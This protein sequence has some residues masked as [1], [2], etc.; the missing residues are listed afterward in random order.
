VKKWEQ[1]GGPQGLPTSG[2]G[3]LVELQNEIGP[4]P[5]VRFKR[6]PPFWRWK[7]GE[8]DKGGVL[9]IAAD[10]SSQGRK[11]SSMGIGGVSLGSRH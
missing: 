3:Q 4:G 7:G 10:G 8:K 1:F 11:F 9:E 2:K 6:S 5:R